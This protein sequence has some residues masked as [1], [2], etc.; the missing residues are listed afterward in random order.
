MELVGLFI[1]LLIS[2]TCYTY[3]PLLLEH[4]KNTKLDFTVALGIDLFGEQGQNI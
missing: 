4:K 1:H 2:F 3:I